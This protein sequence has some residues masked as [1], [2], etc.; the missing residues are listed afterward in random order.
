MEDKD[1]TRAKEVKRLIV[2]N[3]AV[4]FN[5]KTKPVKIVRNSFEKRVLQTLKQ[6]KN[7]EQ[8]EKKLI[9]KEEI[10]KL[11]ASVAEI[12]DLPLAILNLSQ[13]S[14]YEACHVLV[15]EKGKPIGQNY[16][17]SGGENKEAKL[18][19]VQSFNSL[20]NLVKKSKNKIFSQSLNLK[21]DLHVLGNFLAKEIDLKNYSVIYLV[22]RNSFLPPDNFEQED[23]QS[24][25]HFLL[26]A[27]VQILDREKNDLKKEILKKSLEKFPEK[28]AI[29]KNNH[30]IFSNNITEVPPGNSNLMIF[31]LETDDQLTMELSNFS[32]D[33]VSTEIY[34]S[35][36][37]SL[38][39]ELL[40][41]LQHE[42]SNPLFG[43]SLTS[44][45]LAGETE[46]IE[47]EEI[48]NEISQNANRSQTIIKNFSNLYNDNQEFKQV[49]L[50]HFLEEVITLTKSETKEIAKIIEFEGFGEQ[51][52]THE[53]VLKT[54]PTCLTQIIFNLII[55]AAQAIKEHKINRG[56]SQISVRVSKTLSGLTIAIT[57]NGPG[58]K[59]ELVEAIF[60]PFFTTKDSGT[61]LGLSICQ[62]LAHQM[63]TKIEF[64][65]NSPLLGATFWINLPS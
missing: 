19:T 12:K 40:N 60:K 23:F 7:N 49:V 50:Y 30:L 53:F 56:V 1:S 17:A 54:N 18:I 24:L 57:D 16:L 58:I 26:I 44:S 39:G 55:N 51:E 14:N 22:S 42:L 11:M 10:R 52:K 32:K 6:K 15:H 4:L 28:I 48:L 45:I 59:E 27:L 2:S 21:D 8:L 62:N 20:F 31:P 63:G 37:I 46:N 13:F 5:L 36:R 9:F 64:K 34:H 29:K 33:Q 38:L 61:G 65:N 3:E 25:S 41:T 47:T 35:Q 43:L